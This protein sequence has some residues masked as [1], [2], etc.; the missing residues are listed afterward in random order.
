MYIE[1]LKSFMGKKPGRIMEIEDKFW[2]YIFQNRIGVQV[3]APK[4]Q[5]KEEK[6][7]RETK[8]DKTAETRETKEEKPKR[9]R[10][11]KTIKTD[12]S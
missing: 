4:L 9:R 6:I 11:R 5:V 8:E 3:A 7:E 1:L 12:E 2:P 10:K